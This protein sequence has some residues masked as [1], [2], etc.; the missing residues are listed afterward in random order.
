MIGIEACGGSHH[1]AREIQKLGHDIKIMSPQY[2]KPYIKTNKNDSNDAEGICEAVSRPSMRFVPIKSVLQQEIQL[3]HRSRSQVIKQK[4]AQMNSV[5]GL[6]HEHGIAIGLGKSRL[7][8]ALVEITSP[9]SEVFAERTKN[10]FIRQYEILKRFDDELAY[11][12]KEIKVLAHDDAQCKKLMQIPGIGEITATALSAAISS[13]HDFKN[14][15]ALSAWLGVVPR[16]NSSGEKHRM[17]GISKRGD[18]YLRSLLVHGARAVVLWSSKKDKPNKHECW[19]NQLV[20]RCGWNKS[21]VAVANK[22]LRIVYGVLK[23]GEA[24]DPNLAHGELVDVATG[25]VINEII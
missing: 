20:A 12:D 21:V 25:E 24:Y 10:I 22:T 2:V 11:Y 23:T 16:Q 15:R 7:Y 9:D 19:I 8:K 14:G 5:R 1:W 4:V 3:I 17:Q 6:L 18:C 13:A